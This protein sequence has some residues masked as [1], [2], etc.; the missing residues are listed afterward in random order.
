MPQNRGKIGKDL[1]SGRAQLGI[2]LDPSTSSGAV[3]SVKVFGKVVHGRQ[4]CGLL[5]GG[6]VQIRLYPPAVA[7]AKPGILPTK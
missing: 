5:R 4:K 7:F 6:V 2:A 1:L 3:Q